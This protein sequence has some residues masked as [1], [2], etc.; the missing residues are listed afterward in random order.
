[1]AIPQDNQTNKHEHLVLH[2]FKKRNQATQR[3][4]SLGRRRTGRIKGGPQ[5]P[6]T[7]TLEPLLFHTGQYLFQKGKV[8]QCPIYPSHSSL[9]P[10]TRPKDKG[11]VQKKEK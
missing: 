7:R 1:V 4:E 5:Y 8:M 6:E 10:Y 9:N 3:G 11:E 2:G